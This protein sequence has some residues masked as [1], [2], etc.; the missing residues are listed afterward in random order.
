MNATTLFHRIPVDRTSIIPEMGDA[1]TRE[2]GLK[3][4]E[5]TVRAGGFAGSVIVPL[6]KNLLTVPWYFEAGT[7][8]FLPTGVFGT[9]HPPLVWVMVQYGSVVVYKA[10]EDARYNFFTPGNWN[11]QSGG[12]G[13]GRTNE[14]FRT[15]IDAMSYDDVTEGSGTDA[16][17]F[18]R[19]WFTV[20]H[21]CYAPDY[22][23]DRPSPWVSLEQA[24]NPLSNESIIEDEDTINRENVALHWYALGVDASLV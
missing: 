21:I 20:K 6:T 9:L 16:T 2:W 15:W 14:R 10:M 8:V 7:R 12:F 13:F 17:T 1:L 4:A 23:L 19:W 22:P 24:W 18:S 11:P 5:Q 3:V